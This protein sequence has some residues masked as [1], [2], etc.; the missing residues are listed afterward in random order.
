MKEKYPIFI[1]IVS[2]HNYLYFIQDLLEL[3]LVSEELLLQ[4]PL[5]SRK[6]QLLVRK[7]TFLPLYKVR[8][9]AEEVAPG[10]IQ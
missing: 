5:Q 3:Q 7:G 1:D 10:R 8:P 4:Q 2:S 9:R 6:E